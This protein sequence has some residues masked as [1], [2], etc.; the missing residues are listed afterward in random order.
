MWFHPDTP[1]YLN[2]IIIAVQIGLSPDEFLSR[3]IVPLL[4]EQKLFFASRSTK[5]IHVESQVSAS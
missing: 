5:M 4:A 2:L 3:L 1:L